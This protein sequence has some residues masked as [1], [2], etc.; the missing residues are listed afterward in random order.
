MQCMLG[1]SPYHSHDIMITGK[2]TNLP[3][4]VRRSTYISP[5]LGRSD[6]ESK[7]CCRPCPQVVI[8][9]DM[10]WAMPG[11]C[12]GKVQVFSLRRATT[13]PHW[14]NTDNS[15]AEMTLHHQQ[16]LPGGPGGA[17]GHPLQPGDDVTNR[18]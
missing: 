16:D 1:Y 8:I 6:R 17:G 4:P 2:S 12:Q 5:N 10:A 7:S 13:G 11:S 15:P 18:L 3:T 14:H 9:I